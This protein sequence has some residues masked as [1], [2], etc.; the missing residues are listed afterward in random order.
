MVILGAAVLVGKSLLS[1]HNLELVG[2]VI[3]THYG[4][5]CLTPGDD[6]P[7]SVQIL[8]N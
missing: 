5:N 3:A 1:H 6:R 7:Q 4:G 2:I 8:R